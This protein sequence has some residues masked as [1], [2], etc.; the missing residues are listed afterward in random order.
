[1]APAARPA[2]PQ[3]FDP[4]GEDVFRDP[5]GTYTRIGAET[6]VF[7]HEGLGVWFVTRRKDVDEWIADFQTFSNTVNAVHIDV[8]EQ[9][10]ATI[11]P[12]LWS[13]VMVAMDPPQHTQPRKVAQR[14]FTRGR[15]AALE[16]RIEAMAHELIDELSASGTSGDLMSRYCL[17]LTT[18]TLLRLLDIAAPDEEMVRGLRHDHFR[19]LVS[20]QQPMPEPERSLVWGRYAAAQERLREIVDER[21]AEPGEDVISLMA[22]ATD[23]DGR[24]ALSRER[25]AMHITEFAAAGTDTTA[26]LMANAVLFLGERPDLV[27]E[28]RSDPALWANV[29]E[30]TLRR[31]PSAP[32]SARRA[33]RDVQVAGVTIPR[34]E[35]VWFVLG[36]ASNDPAHYADAESFDIHRPASDDHLAFGRGRHFCLGAPLARAQGRIGLQA[37]Y[38]RLP[39]LRPLPDQPLDFAPIVMFMLRRT[40]PVRW[41]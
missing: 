1:M 14:G 39:N 9:L 15:M 10:A 3:G 38:D 32:Y 7:F 17:E 23:A 13:Q 5:S 21:I 19:V 30:E 16:P 40:L 6:P 8:P 34:D 33:M 26:Q 36:S 24:P 20:G 41:D 22:A 18:R 2:P 25:I 11:T 27:R 29:V 37:L 12:Q 4:G 31:R 35:V 28:A